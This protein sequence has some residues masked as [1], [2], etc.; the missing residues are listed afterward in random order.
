MTSTVASAHATLVALRS[1]ERLSSGDFFALLVNILL[2]VVGLSVLAIFF[3]REASYR[4]SILS[5]SASRQHYGP[6]NFLSSF[7]ADFLRQSCPELLCSKNSP[8][9]VRNVAQP[10]KRDTPT[11]SQSFSLTSSIFLAS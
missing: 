9:L 11:A 4:T 7:F 6:L 2:G 1:S 8:P 10:S 3:G 5:F